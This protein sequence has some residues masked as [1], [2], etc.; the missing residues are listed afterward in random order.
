M[1]SKHQLMTPL[2]GWGVKTHLDAV[3][4]VI[5][6]TRA[7]GE[8]GDEKR[9]FPPRNKIYR[10]ILISRHPLFFVG[11]VS[12]IQEAVRGDGINSLLTKFNRIER[13]TSLVRLIAPEASSLP[14]R[15]ITS[16]LSSPSFIPLQILLLARRLFLLERL[17]RPKG[18]QGCM[19]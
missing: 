16:I 12:W 5:P 10:L 14:R 19:D 3:N 7:W 8:K 9:F 4:Q 15:Q 18:K 2:Q 13:A 6:S 1:L 11:L 17:P